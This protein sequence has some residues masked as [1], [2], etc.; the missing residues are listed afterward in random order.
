MEEG[1]TATTLYI[2]SIGE[3]GVSPLLDLPKPIILHGWRQKFHQDHSTAMTGE[4]LPQTGLCHARQFF[5][6]RLGSGLEGQV[7]LPDFG[8][9]PCICHPGYLPGARP[10]APGAGGHP[11]E[12]GEGRERAAGGSGWGGGPGAPR[13][14]QRV[15][16]AEGQ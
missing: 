13:A 7:C 3:P 5:S 2:C 15:C 8:L 16:R 6:L 12:G 14:H 4:R 1:W 11:A 10:P 9:S